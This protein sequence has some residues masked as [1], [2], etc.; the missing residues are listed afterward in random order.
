MLRIDTDK[1]EEVMSEADK[2]TYQNLRAELTQLNGVT[3]RQMVKDLPAFWTV[4]VDRGLERE[5]SYVLT[6]GDPERPVE[7]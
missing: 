1:I 7:R 4:D 3:R 2:K 6:S 5:K